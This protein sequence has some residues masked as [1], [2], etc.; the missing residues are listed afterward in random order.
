MK[1]LIFLE[2][3]E[4]NIDYVKYYINQGLL[5]NFK[6]LLGDYYLFTTT[7][8]KEY[9]QLEPWIQWCSARSG[10]RYSDHG[11]FRLGDIV[12]SGLQ[13]H[14]EIIEK[15]GFSV[16]AISPI[17]AV[18]RTKKSKFWMPDPWVNTKVSGAD[19]LKN[20]SEAINQSVN[21]NA[22]GKIEVN[23]MFTLLWGFI[24]MSKAS[25]FLFYVKNMI[26]VFKKHHWSKALIL[27][28][29]LADV[30]LNL[31]GKNYPD[32]SV[33]FLNAGA[34][35]QHHYLFNSKAYKGSSFNPEWYLK[36]CED[37]VLNVF[38]LYDEII[39]EFLS[40][41]N[42]RLMFATG[43]KQV[44][45]ENVTFYW[46]LKNH[47]EFLEKV[48]VQ[49]KRVLPRMTRDFLVEFNNDSDIFK[50]EAIIKSIKDSNGIPLFGVIENR[51]RDLFVTL[52][53]PEDI[54]KDLKIF[55]GE[56]QMVS[57][58]KDVV[59]VAIKNGRHHGD[60]YFIDTNVEINGHVKGSSVPVRKLFFEVLSHFD[61]ELKAK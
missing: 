38:Q 33:L 5:P 44:P 19:F 18:N 35:I 51:V 10:L 15:E 22:R 2:L 36:Q 25:S 48:G 14:W 21:D 56:N 52:T 26:G 24:T 17:N 16:A 8:E 6:A 60:G 29:L 3:N 13:Q 42:V 57:F 12:H 23:S 40:L 1:K 61:I 11:I 28:R 37:P 7:S 20:L 4:I 46:R 47:A 9:S 55:V 45:Y 41:E 30:F 32:F 39:K 27:D 49:F 50:A 31:Y 59:F 54:N 34:H 53:Y 58:E 43:L